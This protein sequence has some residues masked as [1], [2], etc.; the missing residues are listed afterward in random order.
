MNILTSTLTLLTCVVVITE[1]RRPK[2]LACPDYNFP[3]EIEDTDPICKD[4]TDC[5][6]DEKCCPY[7]TTT[8]RCKK[9]KLSTRKPGTCPVGT[10]VDFLDADCIQDSTECQFDSDC[11]GSEKCCYNINCEYNDC[12]AP[13]EPRICT[14]MACENTAGPHCTDGVKLIQPNGPECQPICAICA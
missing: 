10:V 4:D 7:A 9:G 12:Q 13:K 14:Q 3:W 8:L 5:A 6:A 2:D 11:K 1:A